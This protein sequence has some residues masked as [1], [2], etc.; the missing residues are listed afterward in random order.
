M[1]DLL[2]PDL[3]A[4]GVLK[5]FTWGLADAL[6]QEGVPVRVIDLNIK[7]D[8]QAHFNAPPR[9]TFAFNGMLPDPDGRFLYDFS[10]L[11]HVA[12][13][14]DNPQRFIGL[15]AHPQTVIITIDEEFQK[16][17]LKHH[18][19]VYFLPHAIDA[20]HTYR[21]DR[22]RKYPII[23]P[24]TWIESGDEEGME[25]MK[26]RRRILKMLEG[27]PIEL[28]GYG[29]E[30]RGFPAH[31]PQEWEEM[32]KIFEESRFVLNIT[33][34]IKSGSHERIFESLAAGALPLSTPNRYLEKEFPN[35]EIFFF[36]EATLRPQLEA[37]LA[38]EPARAQRVQKGRKKVLE[39]HTWKERARALLQ[40]AEKE[41]LI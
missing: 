16:Q 35:G 32:L 28:F 14:V 2:L 38:D 6:N 17:A 18:P 13:L 19:K 37:L 1:I 9:F 7:E 40:I 11:P 12:W 30:G 26:A 39:K 36:D 8:V 33:P 10:G 24:G 20:R 21:L 31:G 41:N 29:S 34:K 4:Y 3:T 27:L 22:K 23:L 25:E 5:A 15:M